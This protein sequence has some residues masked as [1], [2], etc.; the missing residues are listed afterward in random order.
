MS[1]VGFIQERD[2]TT[3]AGL[4][5]AIA[6][7]WK[8]PEGHVIN[9]AGFA[10]AFEPGATDIPD[11]PG[12]TTPGK[13]TPEHFGAGLTLDDSDAFIPFIAAIQS[14][15]RRGVMRGNYTI[16]RDFDVTAPISLQA[17]GSTVT[18]TVQP[19]GFIRLMDGSGGSEIDGVTF[20]TSY[21]RST[22]SGNHRGYNAAQRAAPLWVESGGNRI[23][24]IHSTN[25][26]NAVC[27]RG[28][29]IRNPAGAGYT[30]ADTDPVSAYFFTEY[31]DDN[32]V[33]G[34]RIKTQD[35][36][37][38]GHQQRRMYLGHVSG[39]D[40]TR[41]QGIPPHLVYMVRDGVPCIDC[42]V[43]NLHCTNGLYG[44]QHKFI[45][46]SNSSFS[47]LSASNSLGVVHFSQ[48]NDCAWSDL[49]G[50]A[51]TSPNTDDEYGAYFEDCTGT[52]NGY[53]FTA[54]ANMQSGA[55]IISGASNLSLFNADIKTNF[56]AVVSP[57]VSVVRTEDTTILRV[58]GVRYKVEG[59]DKRALFVS[60]GTSN[61]SA[62]AIVTTG[63][64]VLAE[65]AG[66]GLID[67]QY[68]TLHIGGWPLAAPTIG[69]VAQSLIQ[70]TSKSNYGSSLTFYGSTTPG[71]H[72]Y[73]TRY[74][75]EERIGERVTLSIKLPLSGAFGGTGN[76]NIGPLR[77]PITNGAGYPA[78]DLR[79]PI[80][81]FANITVSAGNMLIAAIRDGEQYIR[82]QKV[83][84][85]TGVAAAITAADML[86][87]AIVEFEVSY[88]TPAPFI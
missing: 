30:G 84:P 80:L 10:Y 18:Q 82:L 85:Q 32:F 64:A 73:G 69:A 58:D 9:V 24:N 45:N 19:K 27:L 75:Y 55:M 60:T 49:S 81:N 17:F 33:S 7:G 72:S 14:T 87:D 42:K 34:V 56:P 35:F 86:S 3:R 78:I 57:A 5:T 39:D 48:C 40:I 53:I 62:Q 41:I 44:P 11:L 77:Y 74:C 83:N 50:L 1:R 25:A 21:T 68:N 88:Y 22:Q 16:S 38:T 65:N 66:T 71:V 4:V 70:R 51:M 8:Q 54:A 28:P 76:V 59:A 29:V 31:A 63:A 52:I 43:E 47:D 23:T 15:G 13:W 46:F 67:L 6:G 79:I 37:V 20:A 36:A 26:Y 61:I 2:I 12:M